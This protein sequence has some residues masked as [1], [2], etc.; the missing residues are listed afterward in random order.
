MITTLHG[1]K[2]TAT[3]SPESPTVIIGERLNPTGR[4]RLAQALA[5]GNMEVYRDEA[6]A[7]QSEGALVI[8]V[9]VGAE[10]VDQTTVL[11]GAVKVVAEATGLPV[12]IDSSDHRAIAAALRVF[13]GRA[14]INS[15][16][17]EDESL[18][19][20]LPLVKE[21]GAVVVGLCLD[22]K[23]IPK[24][25]ESRFAVARKIL[26]RAT[27]M[28][29]NESDILI[30]PV[31]VSAATEPD[32][33]LVTLQTIR[34]VS[35]RLG[36]NLT[37]G[38]SNVSFGL[39]QRAVIN[40]TF[41]AMGILNGVNAPIANPAQAGLVETILAADLLRGRDEYGMRYI[42]H[43]RARQKAPERS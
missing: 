40:N 25:A 27:K 32:A 39:P 2:H 16:T 23:G 10:G 13:G 11:P 26:Q 42:R 19:R 36:L 24:D 28:G 8:D 5:E 21:F 14:L 30:D 37:M 15:V 4:K 17:G 3:I 22:D 1:T 12:C 38:S 9:N 18:A 43:Y 35:E 41:M 33:G 7:Q 20:I 31:V 34:L 6:L 29:I